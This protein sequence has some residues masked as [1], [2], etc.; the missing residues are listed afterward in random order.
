[1][2][3]Y[4][5]TQWFTEQVP[6]KRGRKRGRGRGA[7]RGSEQVRV[8]KDKA[9]WEVVGQRNAAWIHIKALDHQ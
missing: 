5:Q 7:G 3:V 1:M 4:Y 9:P 6:V 2:L 8:V